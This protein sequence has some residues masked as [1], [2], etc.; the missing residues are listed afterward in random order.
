MKRLASAMGAIALVVGSVPAAAMDYSWRAYRDQIVIDATGKINLDEGKHFIAWVKQMHW[1]WDG[2]K[3]TSV[4]FN[5]PGGIIAGGVEMGLVV[6]DFHM[7][8][9]VAHGGI[10]ASA[11][12]MAWAAGAFKSAGSDSRVG[13]HM[14]SETPQGEVAIDSSLFNI[15]WLE[16]TGAPKSVL[17]GAMSTKPDDIYWLSENELIDWG[18]KIV[19]PSGTTTPVASNQCSAIADATERL[20]CYDERSRATEGGSNSP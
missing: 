18:V 4:V 9:G 14:A 11:C 20:A 1:Q 17:V 3:A 8:T 5:S 7:T 19:P 13:V 2:R 6:A 16:K 12:V 15:R 10:C